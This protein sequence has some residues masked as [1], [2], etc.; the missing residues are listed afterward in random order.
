[1]DYRRGVGAKLDSLTLI[2]LI[3]IGLLLWNGAM[4]T[5]QSWILKLLLPEI[6]K[7]SA[8]ADAAAGGVRKLFGIKGDE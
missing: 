3:I 2:Q 7:L 1:M 8:Q 4:L 6:K 5:M